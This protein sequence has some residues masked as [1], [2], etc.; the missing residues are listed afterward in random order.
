MSGALTE[1]QY[2]AMAEAVSRW[3]MIRARHDR[4]F[5]ELLSRWPLPED[6]DGDRLYAERIARQLGAD[7]WHSA[8]L[9]R[10]LV[11]GKRPLP[12]PPPLEH[13]YPVYPEDAG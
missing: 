13:S 11:E 9:W 1:E 10:M 5:R 7:I 12:E 3:L 8:L 6:E 2:R 4:H